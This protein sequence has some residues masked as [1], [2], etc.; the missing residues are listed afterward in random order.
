MTQRLLRHLELK[1]PLK[2]LHAHNEADQ[3]QQFLDL[4]EHGKS[5][6]L[7]SDAGTPLISDPGFPLIRAARQQGYGVSPLPGPS[8]LIAALSVS[9]LACH[10]FAFEGFMPAKK[11]ARR[12]ALEKLASEPRTLVF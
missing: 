12:H 8:A 5:V 1:K 10:R 4:L 6:A 9:G 7:V 3:S 11:Q 2:S